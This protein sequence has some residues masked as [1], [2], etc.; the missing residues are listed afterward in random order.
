M[1]TMGVAAAGGA[2]YSLARGNVEFGFSLLAMAPG[3]VGAMRFRFCFVAG[4]EVVVESD[5]FGGSFAVLPP[6][7]ATLD[8]SSFGGILLLVGVGIPLRRHA[9]KKK[10]EEQKRQLELGLHSVFGCNDSW[11]PNANIETDI[12][13]QI[14]DREFSELC[15]QLFANEA[16]DWLQQTTP[17]PQA[18]P[19]ST[20]TAGDDQPRRITQQ[21]GGSEI[22]RTRQAD[23][24]AAVSNKLVDD[25][26]SWPI[27]WSAMCSYTLCL[28]AGFCF[29]LGGR[30]NPSV[31]Q[32]FSSAIR[33]TGSAE[34]SH[35][36][37]TPIEKLRVGMRVVGKNP[38]GFRPVPKIDRRQWRQVT[39]SME[40]RP[41]QFVHLRLLRPVQWLS[42][43]DGQPG[44]QVW[45]ELKDM[46]ARGPAMITGVFPCPQIQR[47]QG[48]VVTGT[49]QHRADKLVAV[50]IEG[51]PEPISL[52]RRNIPS[53]PKRGKHSSQRNH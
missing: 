2:G 44:K 13:P 15:A 25:H 43:I 50:H 46:N 37:T 5:D 23:S 10:R 24:V 12:L 35:L 40:H 45:L 28:M 48:P 26:K 17:R 41:G 49:F 47:G 27:S 7:D 38:L 3:I 16:D 36:T 14:S 51:L 31:I 11:T 42:A 53:T 39:A 4:T 6:K 21:S 29:L 30:E 8:L 1:G 52:A 18:P 20:S 34:R 19:A 32:N 9:G 22:R 33:E